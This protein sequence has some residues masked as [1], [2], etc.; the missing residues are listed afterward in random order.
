MA[1]INEVSLANWISRI[2]R[3][4]LGLVF[5]WLAYTYEDAKVLY[6]FGAVVFATGFLKPKRCTQDSCQV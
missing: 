6:F 5:L 4:A 1:S 3:W 2:I